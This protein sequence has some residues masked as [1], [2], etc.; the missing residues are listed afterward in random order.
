MLNQIGHF[1]CQY[2]VFNLTRVMSNFMKDYYYPL[3]ILINLKDVGILSFLLF[4][5]SLSYFKSFRWCS[6]NNVAQ[7]RSVHSVRSN[8]LGE[9]DSILDHILVQLE[10]L[11]FKK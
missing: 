5:I 9:I 2:Y 1:H 8:F 3:Y 6:Q 11:G 7:A 4:Y 10:F